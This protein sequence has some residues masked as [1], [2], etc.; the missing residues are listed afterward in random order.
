MKVELVKILTILEL[1]GGTSSM[2][3]ARIRASLCWRLRASLSTG[4]GGGP[5]S[6]TGD[7]EASL[8]C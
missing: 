3:P 5:S 4:S 2:Y 1:S 8:S 6:G 7:P